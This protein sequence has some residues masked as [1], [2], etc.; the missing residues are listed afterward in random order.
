MKITI[1]EQGKD[2]FVFEG[3][4]AIVSVGTFDK[5]NDEI[6]NSQVILVGSYTLL[7]RMIVGVCARM[8]I[9]FNEWIDKRKNAEIFTEAKRDSLAKRRDE[10]QQK[11]TELAR[12]NI[13][14]EEMV[15]EYFQLHHNREQTITGIKVLDEI[16]KESEETK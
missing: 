13:P 3:D 6:K 2:P 9:G 8:S 11:M 5:T 10:L 14:E 16:I 15:L 4:N 1:E 12:S 7:S